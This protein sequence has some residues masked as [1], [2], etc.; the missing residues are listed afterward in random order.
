MRPSWK[1]VGSVS[2][3]IAILAAAHAAEPPTDVGSSAKEKPAPVS[4]SAAKDFFKRLAGQW[5]GQIQTIRDGT[6]SASVVTVS[7]RTEEK[8]LGMASCFEGFSFGR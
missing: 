5:E 6:V 7:N 4:E 2:V 1:F 8:G 3:S